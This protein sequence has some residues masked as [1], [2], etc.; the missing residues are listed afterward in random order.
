LSPISSAPPQLDSELDR[1]RCARALLPSG[2]DVLDRPGVARLGRRVVRNGMKHAANLGLDLYKLSIVCR[3]VPRFV[4]DLRAYRKAAKGDRFEFRVSHLYP[5]LAEFSSNA[6]DASGH[7]FH[8]D[9]WA[10]RKIYARR[11]SSHIDVGSRVDGFIAHLLTFMSVTQVDIRPLTSATAGLTFI[12]D[13]ATEM[14]N[15]PAGS[16]ESISSLHVVEHMG[17]GRYGDPIDPRAWRKCMRA[18]ARVLKPGG[19][20]YLSLPI[21]QERVEF[22]AH[23]VFSPTT[24]LETLSDLSLV[25]FAAVNDR[26]ELAEGM[27]PS[28]FVNAVF[29]C[30]LFEFTKP[31]V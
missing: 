17:L 5:V 20:L 26:G 27:P 18:F 4:R 19:L 30:G 23:R 31:S 9:L 25:S 16:V 8:Q 1:A 21:G 28:A 29:S 12:Q 22:N 15:Y 14:S 11:P 6:G 24:V 3:F 7:Y 2:Q 13:D 10:A